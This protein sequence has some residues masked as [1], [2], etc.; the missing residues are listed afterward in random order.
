M[1]ILEAGS[2]YF[3]SFRDKTGAYLDGGKCY[4]LSVPGPVPGKLFWSGTVY[5]NDI[6]KVK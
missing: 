2:I 5:D 4:K 3:G 1:R 6:E